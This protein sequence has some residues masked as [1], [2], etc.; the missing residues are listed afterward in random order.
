MANR[1][2]E[3]QMANE[4]SRALAQVITAGAACDPGTHGKLLSASEKV[5][6]SLSSEV[7]SLINSGHPETPEKPYYP[8][9]GKLVD[10]LL[11]TAMAGPRPRMEQD[12]PIED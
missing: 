2:E 5:A 10:E 11:T 9:D 8:S 12:V 4:L 7:V 3:L 6:E 1:R